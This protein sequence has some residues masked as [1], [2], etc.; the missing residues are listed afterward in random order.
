MT[1]YHDGLRESAMRTCQKTG[2]AFEVTCAKGSIS[3]M[4]I[5]AFVLACIIA[6]VVSGVGA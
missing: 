1:N 4:L 2:S 5:A 3:P 6:V